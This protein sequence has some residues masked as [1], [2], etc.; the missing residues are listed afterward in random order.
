MYKILL[1]CPWGV[2]SPNIPLLMSIFVQ[3]II[4][5][6]VSFWEEINKKF[7]V[8]FCSL[9]STTIT[10]KTKKTRNKIQLFDAAVRER[11]SLAIQIFKDSYIAFT[12]GYQDISEL[13]NNN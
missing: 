3:T 11:L 1:S 2:G 12:L 9:R 13:K 4:V 5:I 8:F 7:C 10:L 6:I